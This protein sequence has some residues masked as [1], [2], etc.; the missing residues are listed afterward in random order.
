MCGCRGVSVVV[1]LAAGVWLARADEPTKSGPKSGDGG[2]LVKRGEYLV[3][4]VAGCTHCH[5]PPEDKG[6]MLQEATLPIQPKQPTKN[7]ADKAPDITRSGL[8]GKWKE[9]DLVKFLTTGKNP[10]GMIPTPP[11]PAFHLHD[12]D[13]RAVAAYLRSL[14][15]AK[16]R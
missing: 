3:T 13:A 12:D 5:S 15:G 2:Q 4:E 9:A 6:R 14:P 7:W 10:D 8:A 1:M 11:M 16:G